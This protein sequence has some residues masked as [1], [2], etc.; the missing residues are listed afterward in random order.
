MYN[1]FAYSIMHVIT[2]STYLAGISWGLGLC[3]AIVVIAFIFSLHSESL[4][5]ES[6]RRA[7]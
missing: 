2:I 4:N 7:F 1:K 6:Y 3:S 5:P